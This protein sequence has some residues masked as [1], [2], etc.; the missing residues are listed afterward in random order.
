MRFE[1]KIDAS[2]TEP[3]IVIFTSSLTEEVENIVKRL[4]SDTPK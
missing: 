2:Y 1:I 3:E 4:S